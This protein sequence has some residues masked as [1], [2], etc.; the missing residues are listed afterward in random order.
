MSEWISVMDRL[1]KSDVRVLICKRPNSVRGEKIELQIWW[2]SDA[3]DPSIT[4]WMPL[5]EPPK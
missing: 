2:E 3:Y 4:H 5:P 1:P